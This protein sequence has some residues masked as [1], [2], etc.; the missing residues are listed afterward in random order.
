MRVSVQALAIPLLASSSAALGSVLVSAIADVILDVCDP[1]FGCSFGLQFAAGASGVVG[2]LL[3]I[4]FLCGLA[5]Y[6]AVTH[7]LLPQ[8]KTLWL[9]AGLGAALGAGWSAVSTASYL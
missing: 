3:G 1:K 9:A 4:L 2:L 5:G 7:R 8:G 6:S